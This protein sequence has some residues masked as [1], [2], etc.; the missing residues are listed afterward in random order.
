[1][2][3]PTSRDKL[4]GMM[5]AFD[6][7][8]DALGVDRIHDAVAL[9]QD[10]GAG[11]ARR[12]AFHARA[13]QRRLGHQQRNRLALHVGAHQRAVGV[14]V[15][16]ERHQR[17]GHRNQLLRRDVDV[18]HLGRGSPA[19]SCPARR[20]F[21]RS[22]VICALV[23]ELDVGL[24]DGVLVL[25]PC[26]QVEAERNLVDRPLARLLQRGVQPRRLF[27]LDVVAH[28]QAAFA[29]VGDLHEVENPRVL[30]LAVRRL[31]EAVL[32]DA[33]KA[34]QRADQADVRTF[35]RLNRAD[36]AVVRRVHVADFESGA[37]ARQ[38]ARPKS[39]QAGACA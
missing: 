6:A 8:D 2:S 36:A 12:H 13:H 23:V 19:Q 34:A 15:L 30:H 35:R 37:L 21:T 11:V 29:G 17:R 1:M 31:D 10:H 26:R 16:Q 18:V 32:V 3:E 39:R 33:R 9:G 20:A 28:A 14:V 7:H 25:F 22:S 4:R 5:L 38:A 24:R 27:L